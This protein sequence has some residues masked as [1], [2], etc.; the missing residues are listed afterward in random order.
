MVSGCFSEGK[1]CKFF[2]Y[3]YLFKGCIFCSIILPKE[4]HFVQTKVDRKKYIIFVLR[5]AMEDCR[6]LVHTFPKK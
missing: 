3:G 2:H 4:P 6:G 5:C 1:E